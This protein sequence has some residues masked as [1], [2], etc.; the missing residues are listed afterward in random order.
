MSEP[1]AAAVTAA[2]AESPPAGRHGAPT[3]D[4]P[5]RGRQLHAYA[6]QLYLRLARLWDGSEPDPYGN[7]A[8]A[9]HV[10]LWAARERVA[11]EALIP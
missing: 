6:Q 8:Y 5:T 7:L 11:A 4:L 1:R 9:V 3:G 10:E 2:A